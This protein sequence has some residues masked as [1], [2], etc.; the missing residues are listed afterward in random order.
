ML[1]NVD[2]CS[3]VGESGLRWKWDRGKVDIITGEMDM[4]GWG[5][6]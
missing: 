6:S 4:D 1:L 3:K 2:V 5:K